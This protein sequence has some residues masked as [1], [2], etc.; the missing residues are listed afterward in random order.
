MAPVTGAV[1]GPRTDPPTLP[2]KAPPNWAKLGVALRSA[3]APIPAKKANFRICLL[4]GV[5][6]HAFGA[7]LFK[8]SDN[9][10][11]PIANQ[12]HFWAFSRLKRG[13]FTF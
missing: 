13:A 4:L 2:P 8:P 5:K 9:A 7:M 10:P 6:S 11:T 3:I 1:L 12:G